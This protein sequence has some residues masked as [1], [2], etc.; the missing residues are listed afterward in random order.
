MDFITAFLLLVIVIL[1]LTVLYLLGKISEME[2]S[3]KSE[4]RA[5]API[6]AKKEPTEE[7]D[8]RHKRLYKELE[9]FYRYDGSEQES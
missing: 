4:Q 6:P 9:N 1:L 2:R 3:G 7:E 8:R 5:P